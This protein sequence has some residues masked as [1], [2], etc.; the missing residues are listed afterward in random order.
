[1]IQSK[2]LIKTLYQTLISCII[3]I[4]I[5]IVL[6][7]LRPFVAYPI[8]VLVLLFI[9]SIYAVTLEIIPVIFASTLSALMLNFFFIPPLYTFHIASSNDILLFFIFFVV[10]ILNAILTNRIRKAQAEARDKAEKE[11]TIE[12]YNTLLNSLSHELKTPLATITA[13]ADM[14]NYKPN[15]LNQEQQ[16]VLLNQIQIASARLNIHVENLLNM[17]RLDSGVIK[18]KSNWCDL[19]EVILNL[20]SQIS[21]TTHKNITYS[22]NLAL[23]L[24]FIDE[25]ILSQILSNLIG[26]AVIHTYENASV[27]IKVK[28]DAENKLFIQIIDT[29]LG[30]SS[31]E[32]PKLFEKFYRVPNSVKGGTGLG[33]S[34]V[35][36]YIEALNG[37]V[38]VKKNLPQGLIF[39][40]VLPV[41]VS[42][43]NKLKNE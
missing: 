27:F 19:N 2:H 10:S 43:I 39:E 14:L 4:V 18:L 31:E 5:C 40:I 3:I 8:V 15:N 28:I 29:G 35:K 25:V 26:N 41:E 11:K 24:I 13:S 36:G 30:L 6:G 32:L 33:L 9:V 7:C 1:V 38:S 23:P 20:T 37:I 12:L 21:E 34:I 42:F 22:E 17:S 16:N